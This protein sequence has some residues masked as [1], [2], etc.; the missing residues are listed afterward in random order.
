MR[1][2][3]VSQKLRMFANSRSSLNQILKDSLQPAGKQS[4]MEGEDMRRGMKS[5]ESANYVSKSK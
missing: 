1:Q 5:K 4:H 2:I 3:N